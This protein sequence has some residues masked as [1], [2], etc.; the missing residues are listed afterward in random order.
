[1]EERKI[2]PNSLF[3]SAGAEIKEYGEGGNIP[4]GGK[5]AL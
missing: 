1:M 4:L 3:N 5:T 2:V